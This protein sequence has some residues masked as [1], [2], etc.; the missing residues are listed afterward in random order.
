MAGALVLVGTPIGNLGDITLRAIETLKTAD[1]IAAEDTR[2]TR[3]LLSHLGIAGKPLTCLDAN[4]SER[5]IGALL[6]RVAAGETVAFVTDAGMPAISDPGSELVRAA[7]ARSLP[8]TVVPGPSAVATA[9]ALSGLVDSGYVFAGFLPRQG[10]K[11]S[12]AL[13]RIAATAEPVVIFEAPGR[14]LSTLGDLAA[15][16]PSRPAAVCRE[17]TKL[18]EEALRGTLAELAAMDREL[19]GE[20]VIVLGAMD[21]VATLPTDDELDARIREELAGGASARDVADRLTDWS[22]RARRQVYARVIALSER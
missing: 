4:A 19:K 17:L 15:R 5:A 1:G 9:I 13:D 7:V 2:R 14:T 11:R 21:L 12:A 8:V 20:V 22:G 10:G 16:M 6:D 18:H 3:A